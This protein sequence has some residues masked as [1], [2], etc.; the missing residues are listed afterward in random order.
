MT[1]PVEGNIMYRTITQLLTGNH[2]LPAHTRPSTVTV[3]NLAGDPLGVAETFLKPYTTGMIVVGAVFLGICMMVVAVKMGARSAAAKK[4]D[5]GHI[6][7]GLGMVAG[8]AIAGTVL[9]A[10]LVIV[11][12][13]V[14]IGAAATAAG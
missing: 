8:V 5:G 2:P 1:N 12:L 9:G 3:T 13:A 14:K 4:N 10:G 11:A 7:E 6:R